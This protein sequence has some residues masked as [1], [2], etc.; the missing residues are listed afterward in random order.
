MSATLRGVLLRSALT[1]AVT[2]PLAGAAYAQQVRDDLW[3][4][5]GYVQAEVI[6]GNTLYLGGNFSQVGPATGGWVPVDTAATAAVMLPPPLLAGAVYSALP[7]G[8]GGW[9]IGGSFT[10]VLG[11][12]RSN[13]ARIDRNGHLTA[14]NPGTNGPV[15]ALAMGPG[16]VYLGG[17]F[18]I[19]AGQARNRLAALDTTSGAATAWNPGANGDVHAL[20]ISGPTVFVGG[21]FATIAG[22]ARSN[23]A[24]LDVTSGA[25]S[26]WQPNPNGSVLTL[27]FKFSFLNNST[28]VYAGGDFTSIGG[29]P[30]NYIALIDATEGSGTFGQ[31]LSFNPNANATVRVIRLSGGIIVTAF[32]GG[33]FTF[34]GGQTRNHVAAINGSGTATAWDPNVNAGQG[35]ATGVF[36]DALAFGSNRVYLGGSFP[37]VGGETRNNVAVVDLTAGAVLPWNP[38]SNGVVSVIAP[39]DRAV[40]LGGILSSVGGVTRHNLAALD[41]ATGHVTGWNPDADLRVNAL[42]LVGGLLY[43]GGAFTT[44]GGVPRSHIA[45]LDV[46]TG[47]PGNWAP[48]PDGEVVAIG[49]RRINSILNVV[50]FGG[51]FANVAGQPRARLAAMTDAVSPSLTSWNPGADDAVNALTVS[52]TTIYV[53]G[54][55]LNVGGQPRSHLGALDV[56]GAALAW[57]PSANDDVDAL[58]VSGGTVYAGGVFTQMGGVL[59]RGIAAI[60]ASTGAVQAWPAQVFGDVSAIL[61]TATAIYAAGPFSN[62]GGVTRTGVTALDPATGA[63]TAWDPETWNPVF[64]P[65]GVVLLLHA[66]YALAEQTGRIYLGGQFWA[67]HDSPHSGVAGVFESLSAAV[68]PAIGSRGEALSVAPNP[69]RSDVVLQLAARLG[70]PADVAIYD[71]AG[72]RVRTVYHGEIAAGGQ[73]LGW[74]GRDDRGRDAAAGLYF[75]RARGAA[76]DASAKVLR[77]R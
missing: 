76:W 27:A 8:D 71:L 42:T 18:T 32:V 26:S 22:V 17:A 14:W 52:G 5:N 36:V 69:F 65:A 72:R 31:A 73:R 77:V 24:A 35:R 58:A 50:Y 15:Y 3:V 25:A 30:R 63:P 45:Q 40:F 55:F 49:G 16:A 1:F 51:R 46:N 64:F 54:N 38:S 6:S 20:A 7:D 74:D 12:A 28:V 11:Q 10:R 62:V 43:A 23:L 2:A 13:V 75:I 9:Y 19:A 47:A 70:G 29:Q 67:I 57:N 37:F 66:S 48:N 39:S 34:I 68:G 60:S 41:L 56:N 33:D 61:P 53:G 21:S 59:H 4:T 44:I